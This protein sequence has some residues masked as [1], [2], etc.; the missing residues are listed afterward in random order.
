[1]KIPLARGGFFCQ[2]N[3]WAAGNPVMFVYGNNIKD[4]THFKP[5]EQPDYDSA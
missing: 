4:F 3:G 1:M 2:G 5:A